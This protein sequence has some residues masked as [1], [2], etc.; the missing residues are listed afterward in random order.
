MPERWDWLSMTWMI[1]LKLVA[2]R[3]NATVWHA[4]GKFDY[5]SGERIV[6]D[7]GKPH[8]PKFQDVFGET[9]LE[10]AKKDARAWDAR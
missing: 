10:M 7:D 1:I 9:L 2:I 8:P 6:S 3:K 5:E 4:P